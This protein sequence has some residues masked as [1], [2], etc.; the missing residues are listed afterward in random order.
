M[1]ILTKHYRPVT[2]LEQLIDL[3]PAR[4]PV[5][6]SVRTTLA[7][8]LTFGAGLFLG[9]SLEGVFACIAAL[10][11]S[12]GEAS[13]MPYRA[14]FRQTLISTFIAGFGVFA[15]ILV[16]LPWF[17]IVIIMTLFS[18]LGAILSNYGMPYSV[19]TMIALVMATV[20]VGAP[21]DGMSLKLYVSF[22]V[23]TVLYLLLLGCQALLDSHYPEQ[24]LLAKHT[25]LLADFAR[26]K[27]EQISNQLDETSTKQALHNALDSYFVLYSALLNNKYHN[28]PERTQESDHQAALLQALDSILSHLI[29]ANDTTL[30]SN[31]AVWLDELHD[32]I[33]HKRKMPPP[34]PSFYVKTN[35]LFFSI[36]RFSENLWTVSS[37]PTRKQADVERSAAKGKVQMMLKHLI[38]GKEAM[39]EAIVFAACM[40]IAFTT[41]YFITANHWFWVPLTVALVMKPDLGSIFVRTITRCLG[42]ILGALIGTLLLMTLPKG[43]LLIIVI[44]I[45]AALLPWAKLI[46]YA[47]QVVTITA[48]LLVLLDLVNPS[49]VTVNYAGQRIGDTILAAL[50]ILVFNYLVWPNSKH[51]ALSK[52]FDSVLNTTKIYLK[53]ACQ[54]DRHSEEEFDRISKD[55]FKTKIAAYRNLS[56]LRTILHRLIVEPAPVGTEATSW[57]PVLSG[58]ERICD[59]ITIYSVDRVVGGAVPDAGDV[60]YLLNEIEMLLEKKN[61]RTQ[62]VF[63]DQSPDQIK[64]FLFDISEEI[65]SLSKLLEKDSTTDKHKLLAS[66]MNS[67]V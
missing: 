65:S 15:G 56:D 33:A 1:S 67:Q 47:T 24:Q 20:V 42:T 40:G 51:N 7:I 10:C 59:K 38:V 66:V 3:K 58:A 5:G 16:G 55:I 41:K 50:I 48:I 11:F 31:A 13:N 62:H 43:I 23:G 9:Y 17:V 27:S 49:H 22:Q 21:F 28:S 4:F 60:D 44:G 34:L 6:K 19:G 2:W 14:M 8:C 53:T 61:I 25:K 35:S 29:A 26:T 36:T 52:K 32:A 30:L 37:E 39:I 63:S 45:F 57:F 46:S 64:A 12:A 18:F 54:S